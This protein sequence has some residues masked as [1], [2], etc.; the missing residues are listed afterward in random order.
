MSDQIAAAGQKLFEMFAACAAE[1]DSAPAGQAAD[2]ALCE[3]EAL[4]AAAEG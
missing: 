4:L 3:L 1:P 2:K